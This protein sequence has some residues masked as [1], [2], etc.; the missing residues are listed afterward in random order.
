MSRIASEIVGSGLVLK[1]KDEIKSDQ[2][3]IRGT[4][5]SLDAAVHANAVQCMLHAEKH[6]D[7]SLMRRL[8]IDIVDE[9]SGYRRQGLIQW[10]RKYSPMELKGKDIN[11]SGLDAHG[12]KRPFLVEEANL[13]HFAKNQQFREK[14]KPLYQEVLLSK[15]SAFIKEIHQAMENTLNGK[16]IDVKKPYFAGLHGDKLVEF[17]DYIKA[18]MDALPA[19]ASLTVAKAKQQIAE[20]TEVIAENE[21]A[22]A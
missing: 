13:D 17:A 7:T 16:P 15:P 14:V 6:G 9:K 12:V 10:M 5:I 1:S 8:L 2:D 21:K 19:D 4:L 3:L 22:V 11:L 20:A 18:G